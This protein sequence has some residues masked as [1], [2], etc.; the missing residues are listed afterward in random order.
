MHSNSMNLD[1]NETSKQP[2]EDEETA[3]VEEDDAYDDTFYELGAIYKHRW[4]DCQDEYNKWY[5]AQIIELSPSSPRK[6]KVHYKGWKSKF[7]TW[8]DLSAEPE[9]ARLLHTFTVKP[10]ALGTLSTYQ[11]HTKC[12][13]LDS[14]DKWCD[15]EIA[16]VDEEH[17]LIKIHYTGWDNRYDEWMNKDSYRIAPLHTT[18]SQPNTAAAQ[19]VSKPS[20]S[21]TVRDTSNSNSNNKSASPQSRRKQSGSGTTIKRKSK[22]KRT[23]SPRNNNNDNLNT[24]HN[25]TE[26]E[27]YDYKKI[28]EVTQQQ[29]G[30]DMK[31]DEAV[32]AL[33]DTEETMTPNDP[34]QIT[35]RQ[36]EKNREIQE[37]YLSN[38]K[39]SVRD[40]EQ[41]CTKLG[42]RGL[43][44]VSM[45]EDGN[46]LFRSISHQVYG[47][48]DYHMMLR[49]KCCEYL[50]SEYEYFG[51]YVAGGHDKQLF[52]TYCV[53]MSRNGIWGDNLEIQAFSE[54][55]G[56]SIEIYAYDDKAMK[57]FCNDDN[58]PS[59]TPIRL[60]Y[61]C[62]SH[63]NS[64]IS[65]DG[66]KGL[67]EESK[68]GQI[69]DEK[70]RLSYLRST[71]ASQTTM[72]IS[73]V[74]ATELECFKSALAES[75]KLFNM[76]V[77]NE[78]L[79][80][81]IKESLTQFEKES[82][83]NAKLISIKEQETRDLEYAL[84]KSQYDFQNQTNPNGNYN[85][86]DD[87]DVGRIRGIEMS[88]N[89]NNNQI[90]NNAIKA[91]VDGGYSLE[92][93]TLAYS[94]FE[95]QQNHIP[96]EM[97]VQR[98]MDYIENTERATMFGYTQNFYN[99]Q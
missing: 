36:R 20:T 99:L 48:E 24:N 75:R 11:I 80:I 13:C 55:Y 71:H 56:R 27:D 44:I 17:Q 12:D 40:E 31:D 54:I 25:V 21:D 77:G 98:M 87:D 90:H 45:G 64:I 85:N 9:R 53:R 78:Q 72:N 69:E 93:A 84:K 94:I 65:H 57:T 42:M 33:N 39:P 74:E 4:I 51:S 61:H 2:Q 1:D 50:R 43:Y 10:T 41:F 92:Q 3:E 58:D 67:I 19:T 6:M 22:V 8:I 60:S 47:K 49:Q 70:I 59:A 95:P 73:D 81:A 46:C 5:E 30:G 18:T 37:K 63:Y 35:Q 86:N 79:D 38:F 15:A 88:L 14:T 16:E 91:V 96:F 26:L 83:E 62:N 7:D 66:K 23:A 52:D 97:F 34:K 68:A 76:N 89:N 82:V 29:L 32:I 28:E